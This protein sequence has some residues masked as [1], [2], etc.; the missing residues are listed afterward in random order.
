MVQAIFNLISHSFF[1]GLAIIGT[2]TVIH[3]IG[4]F[5]QKYENEKE[6]SY[7]KAF[8]D[9]MI[10]S[11][12]EF[13]FCIDSL[14]KIVKS[15][16]KGSFLLADLVSGSKII[17]KDKNGKIIISDKSKLYNNYEDTIEQ[18]NGKVKEY[19]EELEKIKKMKDMEKKR[20]IN[21]TIR[22]KYEDDENST[23]L[24]NENDDDNSDDNSIK[25]Q[26]NKLLEKKIKRDFAIP[27]SDQEN[28]E[29][30]NE[31]E[32]SENESDEEFI[33]QEKK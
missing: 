18:L 32:D 29:N 10:H 17:Q 9:L 14:K 25:K 13:N 8:D 2:G 33:I 5:I 7:R 15:G 31:K 11:I 22:K 27:S 3:K 4:S 21:M 26:N 24:T 1:T 20:R 28:D 23:I 6:D 19:Q 16:T 12:E 30:E